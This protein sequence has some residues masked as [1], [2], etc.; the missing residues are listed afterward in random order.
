MK[1]INN[2]QDEDKKINDAIKVLVLITF[3]I[4]LVFGLAIAIINI[5]EKAYK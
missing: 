4:F 3:S 1:N 5:L 2:E